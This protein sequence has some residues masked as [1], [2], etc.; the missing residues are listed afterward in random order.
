MN[1]IQQE[2]AREGSTDW[3]LTRM[4]LDGS[5]YRSSLI[6]G[7]CSRQSVKAGEVLDVFVSTKPA[8]K[9]KIEIFRTG[10]YGGRGARKLAVL[11]PFEGKE[12]STPGIGE[13]RLRECQWKK[14][15]SI[16]IPEDWVSGVYLGRL[17]TLP[18][19]A[20]EPYWQSYMVFIVT[21][22]RKADILLQCSDNTWQ[23]YNRW[24]DNY[25][26]Y[27]DPKGNQG[28]WSD[29]SFDRPYEKYAQ[30]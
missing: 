27:T 9:F 8:A 25:S 24:P 21:D 15:T 2:N 30:I 18:A 3:Q 5:S 26:L 7:Y 13:K 4:R 29:V 10:F 19:S 17:T 23:A 11:G 1:L 16:T 6:E 22:E 12:Q 28:T 14:C 20:D